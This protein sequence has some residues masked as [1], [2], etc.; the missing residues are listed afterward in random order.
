[1]G[2]SLLYAPSD[3]PLVPANF[4][5]PAFPSSP[6]FQMHRQIEWRHR[7]QARAQ[8]VTFT[9]SLESTRSWRRESAPPETGRSA[10]RAPRKRRTTICAARPA[11]SSIRESAPA[12]RD[13]GALAATLAMSLMYLLPQCRPVL[14]RPAPS[15]RF[16]GRAAL[17]FIHDRRGGAFDLQGDLSQRQTRTGKQCH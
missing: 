16:P 15:S 2:R 11:P 17:E 7:Q 12:L 6:A 5:R 14:G 4:A 9:A 13:A 10:A 3:R 8:R 1:M